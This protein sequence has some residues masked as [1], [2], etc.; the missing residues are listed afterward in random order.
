MQLQDDVVVKFID[1]A[2][3]NADLHLITSTGK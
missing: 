1:F 2:V 3:D